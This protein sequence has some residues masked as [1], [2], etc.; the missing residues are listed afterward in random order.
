MGGDDNEA[1]GGGDGGGD[2]GGDG[3]GDD[4]DDG[5]DGG[6][7]R[8]ERVEERRGGGEGGNVDGMRAPLDSLDRLNGGFHMH[9][10]RKLTQTGKK[11]NPQKR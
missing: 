10:A 4:N 3:G 5:D 11:K 7:E 9:W 2:S 1:V 6:V 8:V